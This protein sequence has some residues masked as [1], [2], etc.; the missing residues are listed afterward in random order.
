MADNNNSRRRQGIG[1]CSM[2]DDRIA[3]SVQAAR[4]VGRAE[5]S[6]DDNDIISRPLHSYQ[7]ASIVSEIAADEYDFDLTADDELE[8]FFDLL[9][10]RFIIWLLHGFSWFD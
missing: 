2:S 8:H 7:L 9:R 1:R 6:V 10:D 3:G 4:D 5:S